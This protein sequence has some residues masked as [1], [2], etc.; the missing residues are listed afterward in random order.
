MNSLSIGWS[1]MW[2]RRT[3]ALIIIAALAVAVAIFIMVM[4]FPDQYRNNIKK[5]SKS[6]DLI[7]INNKNQANLVADV[8]L[9]AGSGMLRSDIDALRHHP[10]VSWSVP[11]TVGDS[12]KNFRIVGTEQK[13]IFLYK[14][15]LAEAGNHWGMPFDVVIGATV[16]QRTGLTIGDRFVSFE[17]ADKIGAPDYVV[18]GVLLPTG[19]IIDRLILT[20]EQ[21]LW[22][23]RVS[24]PADEIKNATALIIRTTSIASEKNLTR[25]IN[26]K[27]NMRF[28]SPKTEAARAIAH[29]KSFINPALASATL[30][31]GFAM[32]GMYQRFATSL[33]AR[34]NDI[35]ILRVIGASKRRI[36]GQIIAEALLLTLIGCGFGLALGHLG[37]TAAAY[38]L[39]VVRDNGIMGLH[40]A[41][42]ELALLLAIAVLVVSAAV[43]PALKAVRHT[44][45][46]M[47]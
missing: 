38:G 35:A 18:T 14:A 5:D 16:A 43:H 42:P 20:G 22:D 9:A 3:S 28:F 44:L 10:A 36:F 32:L 17:D 30:L 39:P 19:S 40:W 45:S 37:L 21:S 41:W 13:F 23:A 26:Q 11:V 12:Y 31:I 8:L 29:M 4:L 25:D 34:R 24:G 15:T 46:E 6:I 7:V 27:N 47:L 33:P 1:Y 2:L